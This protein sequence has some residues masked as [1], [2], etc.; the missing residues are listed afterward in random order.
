MFHVLIVD[1][2]ATN[3]TLFRH[4]LK[5]IDDVE[6]IC[7]DDA[8]KA[9]EWC[10]RNEPDLVLLDYMMPVIDGLTFIK[11]FR[12]IEGYKEIPLIMVTADTENDVRHRALDLGAHDFL[13]KPVDKTE[14]LARTRN[15]LALRK[16]QS[17]LTNRAEWLTIEVEYAIKELRAR[18]KEMVLRLSKAAEHRDPETGQHLLRMANYSKLIAQE[19]KL[20]K[21]EQ[22]LILEAA[23]MHDIGKVATPDAILLKQGKLSA[24]EFAIMK[25]HAET[26]YSIL[27]DSD[28]LL[29]RTAATMAWTH[30]EKCDG[31]GYPR[32]L[33]GDAIPLYGRIIAVA[34]V[35]DALTSVRPYK[36]AWSLGD[37]KQFL[38]EQSGTHF[39]PQCVEAFFRVW[40]E[41][42]LIHAHY[43]D[44]ESVNIEQL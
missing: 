24:E 16:S 4:L 6:S 37:A 44:D 18:E 25:Q 7:F 36:K 15:L 14:F 32:G 11:H 40:S 5:K 20:S 8:E 35:F 31:S 29:I 30:H 34:D 28:S 22:E 42:L 26:G 39:D 17:E 12:A 41:V 38:A 10:Q 27:C 2:N 43:Q 13:T 23:P 19:L 21:V 33:K 9:L 1:D 3:L